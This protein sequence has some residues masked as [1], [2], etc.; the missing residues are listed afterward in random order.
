MIVSFKQDNPEEIV[1]LINEKMQSRRIG[2][3]AKLDYKDNQLILTIKKLG[4][5]TIYFTKEEHNKKGSSWNLSEEK[6][7][8]SHKI[9]RKTVLDK[10]TKI[11]E[12]M[13]GS[14]SL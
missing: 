10:I 8:F 4:T 3:I 5:S 2:K 6:I 1:D 12:D 13:D 7:A 11:I 9:H 14:V